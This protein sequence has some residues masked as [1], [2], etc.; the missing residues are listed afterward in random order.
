MREIHI[1]TGAP[2][3]LLR[4][5]LSGL[6]TSGKTTICASLPNPVFVVDVSESGYKTLSSIDRNWFWD[7]NKM[8]TIWG[9]E[10]SLQDF[11]KMLN[12]LENMAASGRMPFT[13][14]VIDPISILADRYVAEKIRA[15][16]GR[17]NRQIYGDLGNQLRNMILR[18]HAL[19]LH[20]VWTA[21][22]QTEGEAPGLAIPGQMGDKFP[23][24]CDCK[25]MARVNIKPNQAP[26]YE[27][28]TQPILPWTWVGSRYPIP[29]P[30]IPSFKPVF[31]FWGMP[32]RPVSP[33]CPGYPNG[34]SY[35]Q[36]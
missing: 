34:A 7:P 2:P 13:S 33:A 27:L 4:V 21:H 35:R 19:P 11:P 5:L 24:Y 23:A 28:H 32:E 36:Q 31:D 20:V 6:G 14:L 18:I 25:W 1:Q 8:P 12:D 16:P 30:I 22:V 10:D 3:T 15:E 17:D 29:S 9:V 26:Q